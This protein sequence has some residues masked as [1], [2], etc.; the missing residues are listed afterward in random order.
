MTARRELGRGGSPD[1]RLGRK[2]GSV[3]ILGYRDRLLEVAMQRARKVYSR[4]R[5]LY[6]FRSWLSHP[7]SDLGHVT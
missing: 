6:E 1:F 2:E 5:G 7:L 3:P 4:I